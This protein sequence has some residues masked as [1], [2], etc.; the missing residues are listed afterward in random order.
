MLEHSKLSLIAHVLGQSE[1]GVDRSGALGAYIRDNIEQGQKLYRFAYTGGG[2]ETLVYVGSFTN[3]H[4]SQSH[5]LKKEGAHYRDQFIHHHFVRE[6]VDGNT[7]KVGFPSEALYLCER[8]AKRELKRRIEKAAA[9]QLAA[10][11]DPKND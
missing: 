10:L 8:K 6:L 1:S 3:L 9:E 11:S 5:V 2:L 7:G 4:G